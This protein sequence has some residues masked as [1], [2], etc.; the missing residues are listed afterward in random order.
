M[1]ASGPIRAGRFPVACAITG[2]PADSDSRARLPNVSRADGTIVTAAPA[3]NSGTSRQASAGSR[4]VPLA[5]ASAR[6]SASR[7]SW[8]PGVCL[9]PGACQHYFRLPAGYQGR[10]CQQPGDALLRAEPGD[11]PDR[12]VQ[13]KV[14]PLLPPGGRVAGIDQQR[15]GHHLP[16]VGAVA[17]VAG[18]GEHRCRRRD[19]PVGRRKRRAQVGVMADDVDGEDPPGR[20]AHLAGE[21]AE[22]PQ[23]INVDDDVRVMLAQR[24][25][26][27][28]GPVRGRRT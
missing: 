26:P 1:P 22:S 17:A 11:G 3:R 13:A 6:H 5:S 14:L 12:A 8:L 18:L 15:V 2:V 19:D 27:A 4:T 9:E 20:V 28:R 23:R 25:L 7:A 10:G 16:G 21:D 24:R